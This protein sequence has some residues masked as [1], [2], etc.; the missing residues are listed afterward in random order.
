MARIYS[1]QTPRS[2]LVGAADVVKPPGDSGWHPRMSTW[3]G[4][5]RLVQMPG[6]HEAIFTNP[7][8]F[9]DKLIEAERD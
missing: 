1:L 9:A 5:F 4:K 8:G 7:I 3:L 6:S 2:F